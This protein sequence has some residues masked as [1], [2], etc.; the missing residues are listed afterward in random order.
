MAA[1]V[2]HIPWYATG[3]RGDALEEALAKIARVSLQYGATDYRVYRSR[4]DRY[5][6]LQTV[7]FER[8]LDWTR[9]WEGEEFIAFRVNHQGWYQVPLLYSWNDLVAVG[10]I[11]PERAVFGEAIGDAQAG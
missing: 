5:R 2:V 6:F 3:F 4:D 8:K 11:E 1:G 9:Y 10:G 7:T